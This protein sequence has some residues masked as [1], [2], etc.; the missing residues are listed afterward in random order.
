MMGLDV[1]MQ[2]T[3]V[4]CGFVIYTADLPRSA[5]HQPPPTPPNMCTPVSP[6]LPS[7]PASS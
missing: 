3:E 7:A 5:Q 6:M 2:L 4:A 1:S